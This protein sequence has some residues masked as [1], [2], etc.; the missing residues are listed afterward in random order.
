ME[1]NIFPLFQNACCHDDKVR[2][3]NGEQIETHPDEILW[4]KD[5]LGNL[6]IEI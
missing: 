3:N 2:Y 4:F 6:D 5:S 1:D